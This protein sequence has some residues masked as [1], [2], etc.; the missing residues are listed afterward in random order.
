MDPRAGRTAAKLPELE[1]VATDQQTG[2]L[3]VMV[4]IDRDTRVAARHHA[5]KIDNTLYDAFGQRQISTIFTQSTSTASIL[6][7]T[8]DI[9]LADV[10]LQGTVASGV[11]CAAGANPSADARERATPVLSRRRR[12]PRARADPDGARGG[13]GAGSLAAAAQLAAAVPLGTMRDRRRT[14]S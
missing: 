6:E 10:F 13:P 4:D 5:A 7:V 3:A 12:R 14:R 8:D 9:R 2:G 11:E 1:D